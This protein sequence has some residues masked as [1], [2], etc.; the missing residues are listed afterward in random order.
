MIIGMLVVRKVMKDVR[1]IVAVSQ[2]MSWRYIL[3]SFVSAVMVYFQLCINAW[4]CK[5][6]LC[7]CF[8]CMLIMKCSGGVLNCARYSE[9][10]VSVVVNT[11][12]SVTVNKA[13]IRARRSKL[14]DIQNTET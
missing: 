5:I 4:L 1:I 12:A 6:C 9:R 13:F 3:Y 7:I 2:D 14:K 8:L 10:L 11:A